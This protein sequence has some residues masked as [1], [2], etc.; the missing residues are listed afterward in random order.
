MAFIR[1]SP[2]VGMHTTRYSLVSGC[3]IFAFVAEAEGGSLVWCTSWA[4]LRANGPAN[5]PIPG[6]L[7]PFDLHFNP[8]LMAC[9]FG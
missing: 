5:G 2:V 9:S 6:N 4:P 7:F 8:H 1:V 3:V